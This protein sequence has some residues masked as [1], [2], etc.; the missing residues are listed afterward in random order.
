VLSGVTVVAIEQAV[1]A[2]LATRHLADLGARVIKVERPGLGDF[3]R[4]Y[5]RT[6]KGQASYFIWL[7]RGK[8]S[9]ALDLSEP[10]QA[11]IARQLIGT[12]DV[13]VQNLVPGAMA[14]LGLD[15]AELHRAN[16]RL[17][18]CSISGYGPSGPYR[19]RKAYDLLIQA[20]AGLLEVTGTGPA[21]AKAGISVADIATGVYAFSSVLAALY[22]RR[23]SGQGSDLHIAMIDALGEW[24]SQPYY[25]SAY[26]G[27]P[28]ARTGSRHAT[29]A[30]Y[31][32]FRV[33]GNEEVFLAVQNNREWERLCA[34]V[35]RQ[36]GLA[37]DARFADNPRRVA[38]AEELQAVIEAALGGMTAAEAQDSLDAAGIANAAVRSPAALESHP[39]LV[40]RRRWAYIATQ[41]GLVRALRSP[42][43]PDGAPGNGAAEIRGPEIL[44]EVP[45]AG[46]HTDQ[47]VAE[48]AA[49]PGGPVSRSGRAEVL[50]E[51]PARALAGVL[52][53]PAPPAC[54]EGL[55]L[56]LLWHWLYLLELPAQDDLG[57]DGHL[58]RELGGGDELTARMFA[59]GRVRA[60]GPLVTGQPATRTG[61]VVTDVIKNGRSGPL[62][63]VTHR[64]RYEQDG[65]VLIEEERDI[66]Y[67]KP[68][69]PPAPGPVAREHGQVAPEHREVG[70]LELETNPVLLFR[71]SALTYNA[72][73]IHYDRDFARDVGGYP[74]L[75]VHGPLQA[76][77]M[78]EAARGQMPADR[79]VDFEY[80]L[81]APLFEEQGLVATAA[82]A[83]EGIVTRVRDRAGRTTA[84]GHLTCG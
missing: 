74:G 81:V 8:E 31:G 75:V 71:F 42:L 22:A 21:R 18:T 37:T 14:R 7:N 78:A 45:A 24:M 23:A 46:Q 26:G 49:R 73:R 66:V 84:T 17:I 5:D 4:G 6:V 28:P 62:R 77:A 79:P 19:D 36:P 32:P 16:P 40:A 3:A 41:G 68:A 51:V 35:L 72:H 67:R 69:R 48:L 15:L 20:D 33:A 59:G 53:V 76:I 9:I 39:Q 12:A 13:L 61:S 56:P 47:I 83:A 30:P 11:G 38:S 65:R 54:A 52:G 27:Q 25:Y 64:Y 2:P 70:R 58:R 55:A 80:R 57:A 50:S 44:G 34:E 60:H 1:A 10:G 63:F 29:I 82:L 43:L